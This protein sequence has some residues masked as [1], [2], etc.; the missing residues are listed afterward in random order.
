MTQ[1]QPRREE[2]QL[3]GSSRWCHHH[4]TGDKPCLWSLAGQRQWCHD[5]RDTSK[6][7][8]HTTQI[9]ESLGDSNEQLEG[10]ARGLNLVVFFKVHPDSQE[11]DTY[12]PLAIPEV[13]RGTQKKREPDGDVAPSAF[14]RQRNCSQGAGDGSSWVWLAR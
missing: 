6:L 9:H 12:V 2:P 3:G 1:F 4:R 7:P 11:I 5:V 8:I 13:P 14:L 10:L